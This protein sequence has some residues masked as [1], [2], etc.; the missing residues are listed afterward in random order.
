MPSGW[1]HDHDVGAEIGE[2]PSRDRRRLTREVDDAEPVEQCRHV[3]NLLLAV[4]SVAVL[5]V[6]VLRRC[7]GGPS[8]ADTR[9]PPAARGTFAP[10]AG[11]LPDAGVSL[12]SVPARRC[13]LAA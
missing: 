2:D 8:A 6:A 3:L 11:T 10:F 4:L 7:S 5:S 9:R 13:L 12:L 1:L